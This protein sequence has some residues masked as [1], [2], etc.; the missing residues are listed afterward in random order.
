MLAV[1]CASKKPAVQ[2]APIPTVSRRCPD[3]TKAD[4]LA[5]FDFSKEYVLS[6]DAAEKLK[7]ATLAAMEIQTLAD[8]LD[9]E[10][11]IACAQIAHDLGNKGDWRNGNDACAA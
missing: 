7:A 2:P 10:F 3:L 11:G 1:A 8:K 5:A 6:R 4:D 9:A